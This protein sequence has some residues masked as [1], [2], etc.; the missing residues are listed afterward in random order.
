M[1]ITPQEPIPMTWQQTN[2]PFL[3]SSFWGTKY[4]RNVQTNQTNPQIS[5]YKLKF[6]RICNFKLLSNHS[7]CVSIRPSPLF[8]TLKPH[9]TK[10]YEV[11]F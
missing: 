4:E 11:A 6:V 7:E 8:L 10:Y 9:K 5:T 2:N 1:E 3:R